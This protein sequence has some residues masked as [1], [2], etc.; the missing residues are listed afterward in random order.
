M[1]H[2]NTSA[3]RSSANQANKPRG[4]ALPFCSAARKD[5]R[6]VSSSR[7]ERDSAA[8]STHIRSTSPQNRS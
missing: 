8:E 7:V 3:S 6:P 4:N 1:L 2:I 5:P